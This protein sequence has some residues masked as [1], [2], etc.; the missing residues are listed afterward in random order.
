M[1]GHDAR[2]AVVAACVL[3]CVVSVAA[4]DWPMWGGTL[5]RNMVSVETGLPTEWDIAT[6]TNVQWVAALGAMTSG[7]PVV[8]GGSVFVGTNNDHPRDPDVVEDKGVLMAFRESDGAF[9]WQMAHEKLSAGEAN[10]WPFQGVCS[11]PSVDG[12][13]LYYVSNRGEVVAL[14]TAG[15]LDAENDGPFTDEVRDGLADADVVWTFDMVGELGV[16]PHNMSSSAPAVSGD[17]IIVNTS[18]GQNE[19]GDVPSPEAPDL[20]ALH[21]ETGQLVWR[22][23]SVGEWILHGQWSSPAVAEIG[24]VLQVVIGQGDGWVR[25]FDAADGSTLWEFDTNPIDAEWPR[26]RNNVIATPVIWNDTVFIANGQEP[27]SGEGPG[28][29]HAID[30]TRRGDISE[31]G[32]VWRTEDIRRSLSTVAIDDGLLYVADFSGYLHCLDAATG[33]E[34][35][36][37]DTFSAVWGS[38][39]VVDDKVYLGDEDGDVV[40]LRAGRELEKLAEPNIGSA[41]Y[42]APIAANGV[43]FVNSVSEL[44]A[45]SR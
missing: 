3:S 10:D 15:F 4:D 21:R 9:L 14:D 36:V 35:W 25:G 6:G 16:F 39:L 29:L 44:F 5:S 32:L 8:A 22:A 38:P 31:S 2:A 45:L 30:A 37:Y 34:L 23:A 28:R 33:A 43:L 24:G 18:N 12:N 41:I 1:R 13:R 17:L 42:G 26:T 7:N 11:S 40:V 27:E 19:D 20:I